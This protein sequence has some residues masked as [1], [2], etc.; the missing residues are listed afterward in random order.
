[1]HTEKMSPGPQLLWLRRSFGQV[2]VRHKVGEWKRLGTFGPCSAPGVGFA[3]GPGEWHQLTVSRNG[4]GRKAE[5]TYHQDAAQRAAGR[6]LSS[7]QR[8]HALRGR[9][10]QRP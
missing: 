4:G 9:G 2:D 8:K 3:P 7:C 5:L 1:M 10:S 6:S